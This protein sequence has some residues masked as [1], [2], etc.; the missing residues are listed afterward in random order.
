MS[1]HK[2][3]NI[4]EFVDLAFIKLTNSTALSRTSFS[5]P[6]RFLDAKNCQ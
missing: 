3:L 1:S 2:A 5:S 4:L 6:G